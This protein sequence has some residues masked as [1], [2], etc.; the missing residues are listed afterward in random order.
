MHPD[1]PT[2]QRQRQVGGHLDGVTRT[3]L[4]GQP[5]DP[6]RQP[7]HREQVRRLGRRH[8]GGQ[9]PPQGARPLPATVGAQQV[10][11]L[12]LQREQRD[13]PLQD[14]PVGAVPGPRDGEQTTD[15]AGAQ[16]LQPHGAGGRAHRGA[17]PQPPLQQPVHHRLGRGGQQVGVLS[18]RGQQPAGGV[19]HDRGTVRPG[20]HREQ[21]L[22]APAAGRRRGERAVLGDRLLQPGPL[23]RRARGEDR[24][25][26]GDERHVV[27]HRQQRHPVLPG[28]GHHRRGRLL[29][30]QLRA[31]PHRERGDAGAGGLGHP[32]PLAPDVAGHLEPDRHQQLAPLQPGAGQRQLG[33]VGGLDHPLVADPGRRVDQVQ[34]GVGQQLADGQGHG[35]ALDV[36]SR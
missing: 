30:R 21:P 22:E 17:G 13:H 7:G 29:E 18:G 8:P 35:S 5:A 26:D 9:D 1:E 31:E 28:G 3:G 10:P 12:E 34:V 14:Q 23:G 25:G 2:G 24:L 32:G 15:P 16:R 20:P 36:M 4:D 27:R 19:E 11:P 33:D 6:R